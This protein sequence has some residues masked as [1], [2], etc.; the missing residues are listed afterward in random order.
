MDTLF[1][2]AEAAPRCQRPDGSYPASR[3]SARHR[4]ALPCVP[5]CHPVAPAD[6]TSYDRRQAGGLGQG[7]LQGARGFPTGSDRAVTASPSSPSGTQVSDPMGRRT[8]DGVR[9]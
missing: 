7:A 6:P 2:Q 4:L 9:Q 8:R 5:T 1:A 3:P